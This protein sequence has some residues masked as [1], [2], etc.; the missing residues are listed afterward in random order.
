MPTD[1]T[2]I[3]GIVVAVLGAIGLFIANLSG[4]FKVRGDAQQ[5]RQKARDEAAT[6]DADRTLTAVWTLLD[7]LQEEVKRKGDEI[8]ALHIEVASLKT[9][10]GDL[11]R[12]LRDR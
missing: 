4:A 11:E 7:Q 9:K 1:W 8:A 3:S 12:E 5:D 10:V 6:K 2:I